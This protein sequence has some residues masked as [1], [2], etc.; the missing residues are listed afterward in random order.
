MREVRAA[1]PDDAGADDG[2]PHAAESTVAG[3]KLSTK[4]MQRVCAR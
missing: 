3:R 4:C 2:H 1:R